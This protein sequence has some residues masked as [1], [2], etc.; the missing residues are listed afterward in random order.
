MERSWVVILA[1]AVGSALGGVAR[2]LTREY[3]PKLVP[4][5][6]PVGT[7]TVNVLGCMLA[8]FLFTYWQGQ[9]INPTTKVA[10]LVGF[11]GALTT[12]S[13]FSLDTLVMVQDEQFAKAAVNIVLNLMLSLIAVFF[14]AWIGG[15]IHA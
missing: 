9:H 12:F 1:V 2:L 15:R 13:S 6:F 7:L 10:V 3:L 5:D 4:L 11:L 8:G 14:G